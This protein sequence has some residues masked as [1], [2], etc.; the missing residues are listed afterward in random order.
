M[1]DDYNE[2]ERRASF[3]AYDIE[4]VQLYAMA[5]DL[6]IAVHKFGEFLR[7]TERHPPL[8]DNEPL[9]DASTVE[10]IRERFLNEINCLGED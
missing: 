6:K 3:Y 4:T 7:N 8:L 2:K 9:Y 1:I 5:L 10:R